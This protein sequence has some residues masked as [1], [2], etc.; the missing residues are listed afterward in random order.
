M[1][2][3]QSESIAPPPPAA[4]QSFDLIV[5][6]A[7]GLEAIVKR[8][9][10]GLG[11][12][13]TISDS[14]RVSFRGTP[15]MVCQANLWLRTADRILIRVAEFPAADFDAL[16]ETTRQI[17]WGKLLPA[18]AAFPVTGRSIKSTLT[19]VPACQRSV[20]KAIVDAMMRDHRTSELPE[21]G[22]LYKVDV[23]IVKDV[24]TLTIDTT[25]RSLHRRGYR[26]H[27]SSAPL[28]ETLASAMVLLS[29]WRS[30]RPLID[31]FCGSG[32]IPIEAARIGRN[33]AP[34]LEREFACQAWPNFSAELW[35]DTRA[36]AANQSLPPLEEKLLGSDIDGRVLTAARDNA[37]RAGV[38]DD[39]HFQAMPVHEISS[40]K[41]F[42]CLITNPPYGQRIG[43]GHSSRFD[44]ADHDDQDSEGPEDWEL[45]ELYES[46]PQVFEKLPTWSR[47]ILTAYPNFERAMGRSANRRRKL[48]NGRIECTYYQYQGPKPYASDRPATE[49]SPPPAEPT[50]SEPTKSESN[51]SEPAT[52]EPAEPKP[53]SPWPKSPPNS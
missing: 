52:P 10:K 28:K 20:K 40:S 39:I 44:A 53:K 13:A 49:K 12:E 8:E 24:A 2:N 18:D 14:G 4:P 27:I 43:P 29:Y 50:T 32:T 47:Y 16:F 9:L 36:T 26:T 17:N 5:P 46:L 11:I 51:T 34:G 21:T 3:K 6:C 38:Q 15:E 33:L 1:E 7:F 22:P 48:Y 23:A 19:S 37:I 30:G 31:P 45:D 25:G 35:S 41:R 42:G